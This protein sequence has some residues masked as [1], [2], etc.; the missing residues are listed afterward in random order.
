MIALTFVLSVLHCAQDE[1]NAPPPHQFGIYDAAIDDLGSPTALLSSRGLLITES[2]RDGVS[3]WTADADGARPTREWLAASL[4]DPRG[5][6]QSGERVFFADAGHHRIVVAHS[7]A[8]S[9]TSFGRYGAAPGELRDPH[10]L[11]ATQDALYVCDTGNHRVQK[12][13]FDGRP[14]ASVGSRGQGDAQFVRPL[15][16]AIDEQGFVYVTDTGN[17][18]VQKF[19][20]ELEFVRAWGD[21]GPHPGFFAF[22]DGI[23]CFEG[24]V[25][26]VD[27][28]NHRV[29]VFDGDGTVRYEWGLHALLPREGQGKLHYPS[30]IAIVPDP[31]APR[32]WISEPQENR[33]QSFRLRH[34]D[35]DIPRN[36]PGTRVVAA[37]YG[38]HISIGPDLLALS[39]PTAP[40]LVLYDVETGLE[41]WEPILITRL[42]TWGRRPGQLRTPNDVEVDWPR[43]LLYVADADALTI[44]CWRFAHDERRPVGFDFFLL[45]FV[46]S[47]D[48]S[49]HHAIDS[50]ASEFTIRPDAIELGSGGKELLVLDSLQRRLFGVSA[51]FEHVY[52]VSGE[53]GR[54]PVD[55]ALEPTGSRV[56]ICDELDGDV[57]AHSFV[58]PH[59]VKGDVLPPRLGSHGSGPGQFQRPSGI[60]IAPDHSIYVA[61]AALHRISKFDASGRFVSS[62]GAPG[63]GRIQFH[64]PR[65]LDVDDH[66]RLWIVDWGNHRGQVL[67]AAGEFLGAF[68][69][70]PFTRPARQS[71]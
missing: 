65:G 34:K 45:K 7:S 42:G 9:T 10:G 20:A 55:L 1:E 21:F 70:R 68:G 19:D 44:S 17:H 14:L 24:E 46:R 43:K 69:S 11:A 48:L 58:S 23:E 59:V 8:D 12:L 53:L 47:I 66:G 41:P 22:P 13:A 30:G 57:R 4:L 33:V 31:I 28:D 35:E 5:I 39:E 2:E 15:D 63:V 60:A 54:R 32:V 6:A 71:N 3:R 36:A 40:S 56:W 18:R 16:V 49:R 62:F 61:D 52:A 64:R 26:V 50:S 67:S 25:F 29:Q 27:T 37:H 51:D 38:P